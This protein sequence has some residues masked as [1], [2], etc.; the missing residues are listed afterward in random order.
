ME[1]AQLT[2]LGFSYNVTIIIYCVKDF[3]YYNSGCLRK[4]SPLLSGG[5]ASS[6]TLGEN[7]SSTEGRKPPKGLLGLSHW[8]K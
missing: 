7:S 5:N 8:T 2:G 3:V 6:N 1:N 4:A